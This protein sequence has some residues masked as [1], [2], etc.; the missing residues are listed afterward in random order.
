MPYISVVPE[1]AATGKLLRLYEGAKQRAGRVANIIKM[2]SLDEE[3]AAASMRF[4]VAL[5]RE[6]NALSNP[7]KEMIAAVV[8]NH[9][10]CYY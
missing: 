7:R 8:S 9:N 6:P 1:N 2:M 5:M 4:Y 3:V 10:N